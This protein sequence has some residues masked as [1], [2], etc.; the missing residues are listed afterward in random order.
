MGWLRNIS[1]KIK[2]AGNDEEFLSLIK[3]IESV[4]SK[5][6]SLAMIC[7]IMIAVADIG[8][9]LFKEIFTTSLGSFNE[10]LVKL[11]GVFLNVLIAI[12]ILENITAYQQKHVIQVE[13]VIVTSLIAASRKII[14][15]ELDKTGG[16]ELLG[17]ASAILALSISYWIIRSINKEPL[18]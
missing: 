14:I 8:V 12:E 4:I 7:V 3:Q 18:E 2:T 15:L 9:I 13:L 6:L 10:S 5:I 1:R 11:F 16:G 17:L